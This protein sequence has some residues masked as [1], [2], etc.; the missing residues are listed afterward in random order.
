[1]SCILLKRMSYNH[2]LVNESFKRYRYHE[3]DKEIARTF[4]FFR[5]YVGYRTYRIVETRDIS[6]RYN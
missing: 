3:R 4:F 5:L 6:I 2:S 1:M